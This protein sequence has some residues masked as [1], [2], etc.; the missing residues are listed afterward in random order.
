MNRFTAVLI[1]SLIISLS[2]AKSMES[3]VRYKAA[4]KSFDMFSKSINDTFL[5]NVSLPKS[6]YD[7]PVI[8]LNERKYKDFY[9]KSYIDPWKDHYT[10]W[11][12]TLY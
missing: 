3:N 12:P 6:Y 9:I 8:I 7:E 2:C 10:V 1:G 4:T 11:E 5:I